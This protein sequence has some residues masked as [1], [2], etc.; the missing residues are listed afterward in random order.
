MFISE[1]LHKIATRQEEFFLLGY[2]TPVVKNLLI[3]QVANQIFFFF[4]EI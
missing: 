2:P 4:Y 1:T 3:L